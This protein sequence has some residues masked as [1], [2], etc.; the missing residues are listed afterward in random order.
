MSSKENSLSYSKKQPKKPTKKFP[1]HSTTIIKTQSVKMSESSMFSYGD[2][3]YVPYLLVNQG[4]D[5]TTSVTLRE[6]EKE[7]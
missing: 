1:N 3:G 6:Q 5:P 4:N 7:M 2:R